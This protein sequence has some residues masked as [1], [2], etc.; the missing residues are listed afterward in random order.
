VLLSELAGDWEAAIT[1]YT[2]LGQP[3][4]A[5]LAAIHQGEAAWRAGDSAA[6]LVSYQQAEALWRGGDQLS[7]GLALALYRQAEIYWEQ[8]ASEAARSA[9][10]AAQEALARGAPA[11]Q[12]E[13]FTAIQ[14]ALKIVTR[15]SSKPW[16]E[17]R[18]QAYDD[19]FR[20]ALLFRK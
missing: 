1:G 12:A 7:G 2:R 3:L 20:M 4:G 5:A 18:W 8:A 11:L 13:G 10:T 17:W 19:A 9:L 14:Q 6:A 16:P 15:G